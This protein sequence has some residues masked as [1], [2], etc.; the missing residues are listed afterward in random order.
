MVKKAS[1]DLKQKDILERNL[2]IIHWNDEKSYLNLCKL[3][4]WLHIFIMDF[5][6]VKD[7]I[8]IGSVSWSLKESSND[9]Y[10]WRRN[11]MTIHSAEQF[12]AI[13]GQKYSALTASEHWD[14]R[15]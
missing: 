13:Y 15:G 7:V 9:E 11:I 8:L 4:R 6:E 5:L 1:I 14:S 10:I 12:N 3:S 2:K